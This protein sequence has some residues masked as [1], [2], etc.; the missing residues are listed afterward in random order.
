MPGELV[1]IWIIIVMLIVLSSLKANK[2]AQQKGQAA[3]GRPAQPQSA[4][5]PAQTSKAVQAAKAAKGKPATK[6]AFMQAMA[7]LQE[8]FA[9]PQKQAQVLPNGSFVPR[10]SAAPQPPR[11]QG[12]SMLDEEGCVGGS[13]AHAHTEGESRAEHARHQAAARRREAEET[14]AAQAALELSARNLSRLRQ[15]VVMAEILDRPKALR[16]NYR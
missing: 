3:K 7:E 8:A 12:A 11:P 10:E 16:R 15:A 4:A 9:E 1:M 13:M 5:K 14:L 2:K 6:S